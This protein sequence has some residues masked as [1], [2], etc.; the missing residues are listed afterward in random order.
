MVRNL[1]RAMCG[2]LT[3]PIVGAAF[4][5]VAIVFFALSLAFLIPGFMLW[6]VLVMP[7]VLLY[8]CFKFAASNSTRGFK[9]LLT[10]FICMVDPLGAF[11]DVIIPFVNDAITSIVS[12]LR[13]IRKS[14]LSSEQ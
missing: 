12:E 5:A 1:L 4:A 3:F 7:I 2:I 10:T 6:L 8:S 14:K 9:L 13:G 11:R